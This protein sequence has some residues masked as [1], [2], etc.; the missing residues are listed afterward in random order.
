MDKQNYNCKTKTTFLKLLC[1]SFK[2]AIYIQ[3]LLNSF[4]SC[5]KEFSHSATP[6]PFKG[7]F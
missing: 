3:Y 1:S 7:C 6:N 5:C 2:C 4:S